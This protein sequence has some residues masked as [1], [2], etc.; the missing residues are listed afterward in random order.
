MHDL[1]TIK[2]LNTDSIKE[3]DIFLDQDPRMPGRR[4]KVT[5]VFHPV[6]GHGG[7]YLVCV[8]RRGSKLPGK[9]VRIRLDRLAT[10][11]LFTKVEDDEV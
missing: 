1:D 10:P 6:G 9:V 4:L 3:G 8:D 2:R 7:A 11:R 5:S